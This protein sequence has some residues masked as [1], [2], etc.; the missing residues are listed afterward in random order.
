MELAGMIEAMIV[1]NMMIG[2]CVYFV[3]GLEKWR[4]NDP[5][6]LYLPSFDTR[7]AKSECYG[8]GNVSY[9]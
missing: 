4:S 1:K 8:T 3:K 6:M 9:T 7:R 5:S 2:I